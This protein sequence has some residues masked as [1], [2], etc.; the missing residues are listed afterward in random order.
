MVNY[1][2]VGKSDIYKLQLR[3]P[4]KFDVT[5]LMR[6]NTYCFREDDGSSRETNDIGKSRRGYRDVAE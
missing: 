6:Q 2:G 5:K 3:R 4:I 1:L